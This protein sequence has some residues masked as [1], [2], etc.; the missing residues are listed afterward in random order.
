MMS[1]GVFVWGEMKK[2]GVMVFQ[3]CRYEKNVVSDGGFMCVDRKKVVIGGVFIWL[4]MKKVMND[5]VFMWVDMKNWC[6]M[7]F[8]CGSM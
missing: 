6:V 4:E 3:V 1:D 7:L 8:S 2:T 5:G